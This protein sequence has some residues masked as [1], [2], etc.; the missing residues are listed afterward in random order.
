[1]RMRYEKAET[2][3]L[4]SFV[5]KSD[6]S[7]NFSLFFPVEGLEQFDTLLEVTKGFEKCL[8]TWPSLYDYNGYSISD[9]GEIEKTSSE[10][11]T[12]RIFFFEQGEFLSDTSGFLEPFGK[13]LLKRFVQKH[14]QIFPNIVT[15]A[16]AAGSGFYDREDAIREICEK[17]QDKR[18]ILFRVPRRFGKT[19]LLNHISKHPPAG[20]HACF[21]DLEGGDTAEKFV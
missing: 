20:W 21:V 18:N 9:Y 11:D 5:S 15:G 3:H 19:S 16:M 10:I 4:L 7:D 17:L 6:N 8:D 13:A 2:G 12:N 14:N 1:M